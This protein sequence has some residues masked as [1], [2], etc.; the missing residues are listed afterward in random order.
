[1]LIARTVFPKSRITNDRFHVQ[2]L[3]YDAIDDRRISLRWM[4]RDMENEEIRRCR[5][6]GVK[7]VPFRYANGDTRKQLLAR[8][9]YIL[10]VITLFIGIDSLCHHPVTSASQTRQTVHSKK[11]TTKNSHSKR[12]NTALSRSENRNS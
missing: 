5:K 10:R 6:D 2:K 8:A 7:Y 12:I 4:A 1:M 9:K 3:Y 11:S